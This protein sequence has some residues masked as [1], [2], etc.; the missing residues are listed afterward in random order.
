MPTRRST[1]ST[2]GCAG[3]AFGK[4]HC[5]KHSAELRM[6]NIL[7]VST[8]CKA[9]CTIGQRHEYGEQYCKQCGNACCWKTA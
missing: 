8:C 1:C 5:R 7:L 9:A 3:Q 2:A 4:D 6:A